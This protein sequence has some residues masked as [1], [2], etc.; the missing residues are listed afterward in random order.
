M[1][2]LCHL[3]CYYSAV[4]LYTYI[5]RLHEHIFSYFCLVSME[6]K[7]KI[8]KDGWFIQIN[9]ICCCCCWKLVSSTFQQ[10]ILTCEHFIKFLHVSNFSK[11]T[12]NDKKIPF[13]EP[14]KI[15]LSKLIQNWKHTFNV[16]PHYTMFQS[17]L[18]LF[19]L[20]NFGRASQASGH[21]HIFLHV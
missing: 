8:F 10:P 2:I 9:K 12:I 7:I 5:P 19:S 15:Q 6:E 21:N 18:Q 14:F 1:N 3:N 20:Q 16:K 13:I 11:G 17:P 4:C